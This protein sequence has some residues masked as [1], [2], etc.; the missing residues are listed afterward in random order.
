MA[1]GGDFRR[2][3]CTRTILVTV[4]FAIRTIPKLLVKVR[5]YSV[6]PRLVV[7]AS[8]MYNNRKAIEEDVIAAPNV[9]ARLTEKY[10]CTKKCVSMLPLRH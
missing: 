3:A 7:V 4:F 1:A 5:K 9:L 10:S 8:D 2:E 6:A